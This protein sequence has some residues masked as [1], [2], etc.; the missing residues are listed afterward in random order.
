MV[1]ALFPISEGFLC[2]EPTYIEETI[3]YWLSFLIKVIKW[4]IKTIQTIF[5]E[6]HRVHNILFKVVI[7][8]HRLPLKQIIDILDNGRLNFIQAIELIH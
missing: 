6:R 2:H 7:G 8:I 5:I 3:C 1:I 4:G